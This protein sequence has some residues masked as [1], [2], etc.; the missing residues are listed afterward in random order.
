MS[1]VPGIERM[2]QRLTGTDSTDGDMNP[3]V[4]SCASFLDLAQIHIFQCAI[5]THLIYN[6]EKK[7]GA[8]TKCLLSSDYGTAT[9]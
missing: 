5:R 4:S 1:S 2:V 9:V 6:L 7:S 3:N 8:W